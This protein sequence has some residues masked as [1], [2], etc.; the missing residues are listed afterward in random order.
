M[1][2][3]PA[4][5]V[6]STPIGNARGSSRNERGLGTAEPRPGVLPP[7][8]LVLSNQDATQADTVRLQQ[9][10][11]TRIGDDTVRVAE[12]LCRVADPR[13]TRSFPKRQLSE[14]VG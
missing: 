12:P 1:H 3:R 5:T 14:G 4:S 7:G 10:S 13:Y 2:H 6:L 11:R 8:E 9:G